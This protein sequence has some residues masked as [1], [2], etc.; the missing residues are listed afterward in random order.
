M[1]L[2]DGRLLP[3]QGVG[4]TPLHCIEILIF[5][6]TSEGKGSYFIFYSSFGLRCMRNTALYPYLSIESE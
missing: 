3:G 4:A 1:G 2:S 5:L 6:L